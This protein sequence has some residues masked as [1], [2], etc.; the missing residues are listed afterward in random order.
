[1]CAG[2]SQL[3]GEAGIRVAYYI[4]HVWSLGHVLVFRLWHGIQLTVSTQPRRQLTQCPN[5][6]YLNTFDQPRLSQ[7]GLRHR[8]RRPPV[9]LCRQ[10][11]R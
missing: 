9:T 11:G 1:M 5:A 4:R 2:R 3:N 10:Y 7:V 6:Q 8:D